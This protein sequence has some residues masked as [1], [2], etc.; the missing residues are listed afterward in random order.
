M[1]NVTA[2]N[3][4]VSAV[5]TSAGITMNLPTAPAHKPTMAK[6]AATE[7]RANDFKSSMH[8]TC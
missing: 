8:S 1:N 6:P 5:T 4:D 7:Q 3:N 2:T